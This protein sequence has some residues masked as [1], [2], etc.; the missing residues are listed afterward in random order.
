[1]SR[2]MVLPAIESSRSIRAEG[3]RRLLAVCP[4]PLWP[5][6]NG[7][8]LRVVRLLRELARDWEIHL[9]AATSPPGDDQTADLDLAGHTSVELGGR[10]VTMPWQFDS[11]RLRPA[12]AEVVATRRPH[13]ALLWSGSEFLAPLSRVSS[14]VGDRIDCA[15]VAG[16]R[17]LPTHRSLRGRAAALR[18][19][20]RAAWYERN[21]VRAL[22]AMT[23]V[24]DADATV[25]RLLS[26][27][28]TVYVVP[29]G[30]DAG[31][32][33]RPELESDEPSI[34]FTGVMSFG[35]NVEAARYFADHVWPLVYA[36]RPDARFVIA[37]RSPLPAVVELGER[38]GVTLLPDVPSIDA[39]LRTCWLAVAPMRTGT[40]I[41]NKV[42]EAWAAGKP[43]VMS[44]LARNGLRV[45]GPVADLVA[46]EPDHFASLVLSLLEEPERRLR[47]GLAAREA[48]TRAHSWPGAAA[49]LTRL[50]SGGRGDMGTDGGNG[51]VV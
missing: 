3:G 12:V 18:V 11:E 21:A 49:Q 31:P 14:V 42:L 9:V 16:W 5:G 25:L 47:L 34:V 39:V 51:P 22:H 20:G 17:A 13:A 50:L 33:P 29:N 10:I 27:R 23:V 45:Q 15:T 36:R 30:V 8:S 35:P 6:N 38:P 24:G 26:G 32:A 2:A 1:M 37:G 7:Y 40:G 44:P 28:R 46:R 48:V 41:K 43:V 4:V 19:A